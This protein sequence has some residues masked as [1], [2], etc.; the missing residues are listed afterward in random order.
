M[1]EQLNP[2]VGRSVDVLGIPTNYLEAGDGPPLVLLH[3]S[4]PGVS[5]HANWAGVI[6]GLSRSFRV[7]AVDCPGFGHSGRKADGAYSMPF[8]IEHFLAFLDAL[9]LKKVSLVGNSFGGSLS[10]AATATA[11]E[12]FDKLV[13]MGTPCGRFKITDGLR[14]SRSYTPSPANLRAM[15]EMFPFDKSIVTDN[16]V[17]ARLKASEDPGSLIAFRALVPDAAIAEGSDGIISGVPEKIV[18]RLKQP[19]LVLHGRDDTVVPME[20]GMRIFMNAPNAQFHGF[21]S[22]GHWVQVERREQFIQAAT[23]FLQEGMAT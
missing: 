5:A 18:A 16:M 12:R 9:D 11:P 20:L 2:G 10:L 3:G 22:C 1:S 6:P 21:G 17:A 19:I 8:W 4:G 14:A 23:A 7:I 15:L 13:L